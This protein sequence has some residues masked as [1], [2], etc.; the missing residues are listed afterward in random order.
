MLKARAFSEISSEYDFGKKEIKL[1]SGDEIVLYS[2]I[3][4]GEIRKVTSP[5]CVYDPRNG[6]F[7]LGELDIGW[8]A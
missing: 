6:K 4:R 2:K 3:G 5:V 8:W 7:Y 1:I